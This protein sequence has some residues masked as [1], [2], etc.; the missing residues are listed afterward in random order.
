M[1]LAIIPALC[2][3]ALSGCS[4]MSGLDAKTS[5]SCKA[6]D[7]VLCESMTGIYANAEAN[8]LPGQRVNRHGKA[9]QAA[10]T[11]GALTQPISSGTPIRSAPVV[12]RVWFAPWEDN[13][14]DLHDQNYLYMTVSS[15]KWLIEHSHARIR[16]AYR[17]VRPPSAQATEAPIKTA[18]TDS[19]TSSL[20]LP[21]FA[22]AKPAAE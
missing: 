5:F 20:T 9:P 6:P 17:P 10:A 22:A 1:K 7:G 16:D 14:G 13:D 18:P 19:S 8:N 2:A 3:L 15:G 21:S 4:S 12:M 11:T